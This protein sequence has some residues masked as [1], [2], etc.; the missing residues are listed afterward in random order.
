MAAAVAKVALE[1]SADL[2]A[3]F[4][5]LMGWD[6]RYHKDNTVAPLVLMEGPS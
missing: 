5:R 4:G 6:G 2:R 3:D 1:D